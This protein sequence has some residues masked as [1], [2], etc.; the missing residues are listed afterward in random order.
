MRVGPLARLLLAILLADATAYAA[1][2]PVLHGGPAPDPAAVEDARLQAGDADAEVRWVFDPLAERL[3]DTAALGDATPSPCSADVWAASDF[4]QA[5]EA[6]LEK[7]DL[8]LPDEAAEALEVASS[9]LV[10]LAEPPA[11]DALAR[12][13]FVRGLAELTRAERDADAGR[14]AFQAAVTADPDIAWD[15]DYPAFPRSVFFEAKVTLLTAPRARVWLLPDADVQVWLEG[16]PLTDAVGGQEIL[17]GEHL[18]HVRTSEGAWRGALVVQPGAQVV[19]GRAE[20][21]WSVLIG[22]E[23]TDTE[24]ARAFAVRRAIAEAHGGAVRVVRPGAW[25][26]VSDAGDLGAWSDEGPFRPRLHI[27]VGIG[28]GFLDKQIDLPP[29]DIPAP[30]SHWGDPALGVAVRL[31]PR[32]STRVAAGLS[33]SGPFSV[34][35]RRETRLMGQLSVGAGHEAADGRVR[36]GARVDL[37]A[38]F[39]GALPVGGESSFALLFGPTAVGTLALRATDRLWLHAEAGGGW[40]GTARVT[41]A[42]RLQVRLPP[43]R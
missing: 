39:P 28:W 21:V 2:G 43:R 30:S 8:I 22:A 35:D 33:W 37:N 34:D 41:G 38:F 19:L 7:L 17:A 36:P 4:E 11:P 16:R 27:D 24:N 26:P 3:A 29:V 12:L 23:A 10:C 20:S 14:E 32:W 25:A 40:V 31:S 42:V 18:V 13:H 6:G 15:E 9:R 1:D 5:L